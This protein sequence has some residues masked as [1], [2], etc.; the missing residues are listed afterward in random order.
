M[1][2]IDSLTDD[3]LRDVSSAIK[4][5]G[6]ALAARTDTKAS[7]VLTTAERHAVGRLML[8]VFKDDDNG[9]EDQKP[10]GV[11]QHHK[12]WRATEA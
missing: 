8:S 10:D 1:S 5:L 12:V 6:K 9:T 11:E 4:K 3:E 7:E 2:L